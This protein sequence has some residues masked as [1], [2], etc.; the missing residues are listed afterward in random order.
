M[1]R[2]FNLN[3]VALFLQEA[4]NRPRQIGAIAPS[5]RNLAVAMARWL[6]PERDHFVL[7]LGPGTGVVTRALLEKGL[8]EDRLVAIEMSSLLADHLRQLFPQANII[9]GDALDLDQ[10]LA[11]HAPHA[12]PFPIVF[13]SLP[14]C[15]FEI[16]AARRLTGKIRRMLVPG[17]KYIQ[18]SYRLSMKRARSIAHFQYVTSQVVWF[19]LPPARVSVYRGA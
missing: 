3:G 8:P 16:E 9:T 18:Y 7:E 13:S 1:A 14:L 11:V 15:N 12:G 10:L 17:G 5:S 2:H 4:F 19:N 6:P